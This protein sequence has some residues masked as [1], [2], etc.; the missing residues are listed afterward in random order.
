VKITEVIILL[1]ALSHV[2]FFQ[3]DACNAQP[4]VFGTLASSPVYAD[5]LAMT[6]VNVVTYGVIWSQLEPERNIVN[7]VYVQK[8]KSD[9]AAFKANRLDVV[10]DFG[11]QYPPE[12]IKNTNHAMYINQYGEVFDPVGQPG[13]NGLN[14]VFNRT[15]RDAQSAHVER[16]FSLF[17]TDFYAVRLGWGLYGELNYPHPNHKNRKN[18]YWAFDPIA[19][20]HIQGLPEGVTSC[21]VPGWMPGTASDNHN[22]ARQFIDWYLNALKNYHDWQ[23]TAV[24]KFHAGKIVMLMGSWGIRYGDIEGYI[25][26][27]LTDDGRTEIQRGFDFG[28][29]IAGVTDPKYIVCSTWIDTPA[30]FCDDASSNPSRWSPVHYLAFQAQNHPLKLKV[31]GENTGPGSVRDMQLTFE[32]ARAFAV[33]AVI[34]AFEKDLFVEE[35]AQLSDYL[36]LIRQYT[37]K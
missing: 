34:W 2:V 12:W 10:L 31:W 15:I 30:Q 26:K 29:Y 23:I 16:F 22:A 1:Y 5:E 14:A 4:T 36:S 3:A 21:P 33:E 9:L 18:C 6:P 20:G 24:R 19:Q 11:L 32:R 28:K 35:H 25:Q 13:A 37:Q 17:G 27:D 8:V 7:E